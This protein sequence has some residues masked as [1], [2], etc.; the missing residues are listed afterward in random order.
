MF[1]SLLIRTEQINLAKKEKSSLDEYEK[2]IINTFET[3][4][5]IQKESPIDEFDLIKNWTLLIGTD[6][7]TGNNIATMQRMSIMLFMSEILFWDLKWEEI[8]DV[9]TNKHTV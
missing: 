2:E 6:N 8:V 5:Q 4:K 9:Y 1:V 3:L 7:E